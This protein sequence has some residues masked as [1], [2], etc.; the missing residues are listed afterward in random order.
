[1]KQEEAWMTFDEIKAVYN[2]YLR[3]VKAM[4]NK[5]LLANY[6]KIVSY[7]LLACTTGASGLPPRRSLDYTE[8]KIHNYDTKKDNYYKNGV[9]YFN[10]YL[11]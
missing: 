11:L 10:I 7:I 6:S 1:M 4:F 9:F 5:K 2:D 8:M 3:D